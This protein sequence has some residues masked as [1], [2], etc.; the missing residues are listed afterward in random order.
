[1]RAAIA[2]ILPILA[3]SVVYDALA[4]GT[5][6]VDPLGAALILLPAILVGLLFVAL[7]LLPLW[8][9]FSASG[10]SRRGAF[11]ATGAAIWLIACL[12]LGSVQQGGN[13][14]VAMSWLAPGLVLVGTFGLLM[15]ER[16][17]RLKPSEGGSTAGPA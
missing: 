13:I 14:R 9:F 2:I 8:S 12:V 1:M 11:V 15:R 6:N 4:S 10:E 5:S 16:R 7:V 17:R 3:A